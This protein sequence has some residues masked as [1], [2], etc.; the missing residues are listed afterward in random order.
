MVIT[1][2]YA[3]PSNIIF[4]DILSDPTTKIYISVILASTSYIQNLILLI[5]YVYK[6]STI[7]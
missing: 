3:R 2:G 7:I 5:S 4:S 1:F 6:N